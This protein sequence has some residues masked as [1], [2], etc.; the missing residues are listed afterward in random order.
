MSPQPDESPAESPVAVS[1]E[2]DASSIN[3][4]DLEEQRPPPAGRPH[5]STRTKAKASKF[6]VFAKMPSFRRGIS[7]SRDGRSSKNSSPEG[8]VADLLFY[9]THPSQ[10]PEGQADNSDDEVFYKSDTLNQTVNQASSGSQIDTEEEEEGVDDDSL[11]FLPCSD[12]IQDA[13]DQR[14]VETEASGVTDTAQLKQS[15]ECSGYKRSKSTE[16]LSLR[17]RF[18][19]AHKSLSSLFE[20]RAVDKDSEE[21]EA[22]PEVAN[23]RP[24]PSW[25]KQ[26]RAKEAEL[27]RRT[28]SVPDADGPKA[29]R[30]IHRDYAS[31]TTQ[32]RLG[33]QGA[34]QCHTDPLSKRGVPQDAVEGS[35]QGSKSE[36][37]RRKCLRN[38][39][40]TS[41]SDSGRLSSDDS[42]EA[43]PP[44]DSSPLLSMTPSTPASQLSPSWP[45][46]PPGTSDSTE[47]PM[48]PMSPKPNSP[49]S[50]GS[51]RGFRYPSSRTNTLSL[52]LLG[53]AASVPDPPERPRTLKPKVGRQGSLSPLGSSWPLE[54]S[55]SDSQSQVSLV[56]VSD[57]EVSID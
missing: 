28:M 34:A 54:D 24:R 39:L 40:P 1:V 33:Q 37:R 19:Q 13:C 27:L 31:R 20:S 52:I 3:S 2:L 53:Q 15:G 42:S 6:S 26:K 23:E 50:S 10:T 43:V 51:R 36:G 14:T 17:L 45:K 11:V 25:R 8:G 4:E 35:P 21:R 29:T 18:A 38:G 5:K 47:S 55:S 57:F 9:R 49:R 56:T 46:S 7:V 48:R 44:G 30:L 41:F 32:E 16:G 22:R 12:Q